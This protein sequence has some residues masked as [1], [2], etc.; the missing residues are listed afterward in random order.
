MLCRVQA[1]CRAHMSALSALER[2]D[3]DALRRDLDLYAVMNERA[4]QDDECDLWARIQ[5]AVK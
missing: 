1:R 4:W 5:E 3:V 2:G